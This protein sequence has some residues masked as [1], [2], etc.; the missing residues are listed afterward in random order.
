MNVDEF[1]KSVWQC[2]IIYDVGIV[3]RNENGFT[4]LDL[5]LATLT[6]LDPPDTTK[7]KVQVQNAMQTLVT[8]GSIGGHKVS[9]T[10]YLDIGPPQIGTYSNP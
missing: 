9:P 3:C 1:I 7:L 10:A 8:T 5:T 4:G 6:K 2:A